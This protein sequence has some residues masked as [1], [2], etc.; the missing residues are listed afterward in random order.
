MVINLLTS[1]PYDGIIENEAACLHGISVDRVRQS[2]L[3]GRQSRGYTVMYNHTL[4]FPSIFRGTSLQEALRRQHLTMNTTLDEEVRRL[5]GKPQH[6]EDAYIASAIERFRAKIPQFD[7]DSEHIQKKPTYEQMDGSHFVGEVVFTD[8]TY[9]AWVVTFGIPYTGNLDYLC[10][11]P[12]SGFTM[13]GTLELT[14]DRQ[15][16]YVKTWTLDRPEKDIQKIA[17]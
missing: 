12:R 6:D 17:A 9:Q 15:F 14:Y 16:V 13:G 8:R 3:L 4:T 11:I 7:F 5:G 1:R 10:Y 2:G